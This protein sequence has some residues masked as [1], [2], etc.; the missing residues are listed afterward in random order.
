MVY[1]AD[2]FWKKQL[3]D[4]WIVS[5]VNTVSFIKCRAGERGLGVKSKNR[6]QSRDLGSSHRYSVS[7]QGWKTAFTPEGL[8][9]PTQFLILE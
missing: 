3:I 7:Q 8:F 2:F 1:N 4:L 5:K 6:G 9:S